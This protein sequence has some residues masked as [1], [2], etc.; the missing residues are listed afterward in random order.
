M[1]SLLAGTRLLQDA[2]DIW[3]AANLSWEQLQPLLQGQA[4]VEVFGGKQPS[5]SDFQWAFSMLL[6]RLIR[7]SSLNDTEALVS[8]ALF[9]GQLP[10]LEERPRKWKSLAPWEHCASG[11]QVMEAASRSGAV[12]GPAQSQPC[13]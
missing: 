11:N 2:R 13:S 7:L 9:V 1:D 6:S 10:L 5:R 12:G 8:C 3:A 4:A